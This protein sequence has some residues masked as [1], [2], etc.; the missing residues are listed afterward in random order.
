MNTKAEEIEVPAGV[1]VP[2]PDMG[3]KNVRVK[4]RCAN[5]PEF[6]GVM[7]CANPATPAEALAGMDFETRY[8]IVCAKPIARRVIMVEE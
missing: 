6:R 8:R 2:C 5:C 4:T 3:F 1:F 7:D